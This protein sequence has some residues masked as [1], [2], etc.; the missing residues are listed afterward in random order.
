VEIADAEIWYNVNLWEMASVAVG[1]M[2]RS[3]KGLMNDMIE[4]EMIR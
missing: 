2:L 3:W 4:R 1:I